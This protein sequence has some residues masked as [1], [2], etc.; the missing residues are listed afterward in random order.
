MNS[1]ADPQVLA[2]L[3]ELEPFWLKLHQLGA[4]DGCGK[5]AVG[6]GFRW[7]TNLKRNRLGRTT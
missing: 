4:P 1:I 5:I 7:M 6:E 2:I 3:R